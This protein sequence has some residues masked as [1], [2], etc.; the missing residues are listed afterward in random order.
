MYIWLSFFIV[1]MLLLAACLACFFDNRRRRIP[2]FSQPISFLIPCYNDGSTVAGTIQS[3][4]AIRDP[5]TIEIVVANDAS[6]DNSAAILDG[7]RNQYPIQVVHNPVNLGKAETLNRLA[8]RARHDL[9]VFVDADT[10]L[11]RVALND[12]TTRLA[13][14][15]NLGAV[16]CPYR[17]AN[18]GWLPRL[19]SIDYSMISVLQGAYNYI[20]GLALWGGCIAVRK[21]AFE[22]VGGFSLSAITEDVNLA[23]MLNRTGWRVEQSMI[24]VESHV[25]DTCRGWIKQKIRWTAG[26]FQCLIRYPSVWMRHPLQVMLILLYSILSL[27]AAF[28]FVRHTLLLDR[29]FDLVAPLA[30]ILPTSQLVRMLEQIY[31]AT[32]L[33]S[34]QLMFCF[35]LLS[36]V[37]VVPLISKWRDSTLLL[38][39]IPFSLAYFPF[40][41]LLSF[42]GLIYLITNTRRIERTLRAW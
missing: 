39:I 18:R 22:E 33:G 7:L 2:S 8:K 40:Y 11:N 12:M 37:Y 19:Q 20:S 15:P 29:A 30:N 25:P 9:I 28:T 42:A 32:M 13:H 31:G 10:C 41:T 38:L 23:Y 14:D 26:G 34:L 36:A 5:A 6:T 27:N 17:P 3:I 21:A 35:T 24:P 16:S 4:L 1:T